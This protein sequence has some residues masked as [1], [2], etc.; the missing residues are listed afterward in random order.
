MG[1]K[2]TWQWEMIDVSWDVEVKEIVPDKKTSSV[3][4][5]HPEKKGTFTTPDFEFEASTDTTTHVIKKYGF[6]Q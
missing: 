5:G 2:I 6:Y 3:E 1:E 4:W